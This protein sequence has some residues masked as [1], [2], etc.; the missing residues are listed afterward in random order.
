M[1]MAAVIPTSA[2]RAK[3]PAMS[4][5]LIATPVFLANVRLRNDRS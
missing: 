3:S 4:S 5:S 1:V 2:Q